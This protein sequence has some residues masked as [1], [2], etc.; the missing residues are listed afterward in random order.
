MEYTI[1]QNHELLSDGSRFKISSD[2]Q[3]LQKDM[4]VLVGTKREYVDEVFLGAIESDA[5]AIGHL[6]SIYFNGSG[7]DSDRAFAKTLLKEVT[8]KANRVFPKHKYALA[9]CHQMCG[10]TSKAIEIYE[11][12]VRINFGMAMTQMGK[13][14]L[15]GE[16]VSLDKVLGEGL[17]RRGSK[18]GN[19]TSRGSY[20]KY[21]ISEKSISK[22]IKGMILTLRNILP[23]MLY[24]K[25]Q[26]YTGLI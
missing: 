24:V 5:D 3:S 7:I 4:T 18:T 8:S 22:K 26:R 6:A 1:S 13:L 14:H 15:S 20:A 11:A 2:M 19:V 17:L 23:V 10:E 12:L 21:L 9:R 16:G 25:T